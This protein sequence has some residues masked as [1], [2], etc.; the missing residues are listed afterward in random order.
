MAASSA[1]ATRRAGVSMS[2]I[3]HENLDTS[4]RLV[5]PFVPR[6]RTH[7]PRAFERTVHTDSRHAARSRRPRAR[8]SSIRAREVIVT[9]P[10]S[11][12][13]DASR[14]ASANSRAGRTLRNASFLDARGREARGGDARHAD[15]RVRRGVARSAGEDGERVSERVRSHGSIRDESEPERGDF[16]DI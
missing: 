16:E 9:S 3:S 6:A 13:R 14:V 15:V 7:R 4:R 5:A 11:R 10:P 8:S 1:G 12:R 2:M